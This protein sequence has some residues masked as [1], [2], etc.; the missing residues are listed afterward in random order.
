MGKRPHIGVTGDHRLWS[1]SW[2]C[3][4]L[5]LALTGASAERISVVSPCFGKEFDG[6][7]VSGGDDIGPE[8]YGGPEMPKARIDRRR[9]ALEAS[10]IRLALKRGLPVLGICR[11]AQ[12]LN[13]ILGGSLIQDVRSLRNKTS[14]RAS[15]LPTKTVELCD[16][17]RLANEVD[18]VTLRV[19]SLHH[20]AIL[21]PGDN[22]RIVGRDRDALCQAI[23]T[24]DEL[25]A[26][27]VQWHPEYLFYMPSQRR[28]F[29]WLVARAT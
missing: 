7:I 26:L 28:V 23:E 10:W 19:N 25:P 18:S 4:K 6:L 22:L 1:P 5:V 15:L 29:Q 27:G 11:G 17:S 8:L 24:R 12:L 3:I 16:E 9:D 13:V 2:W 14:N 21:Q 20:Q